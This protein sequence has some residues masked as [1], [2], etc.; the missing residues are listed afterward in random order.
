MKVTCLGAARTV[1]GSSFLLESNGIHILID[2]GMF[3]GRQ[4]IQKRNHTFH[5]APGDIDYLLLTHAHID[6]IGRVPE[7]V[8][9]GF[10]GEII[11]THGTKALLRPML[12]DA[13]SFSAY[14][15]MEAAVYL[16][17]IDD[18]AWGV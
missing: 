1:T 16:D 18:L 13:M 3:Q 7:L 14:S 6:H 15:E 12:E 17:T 5:Y 2:C 10:K 11:T 8:R 9:G 4:E